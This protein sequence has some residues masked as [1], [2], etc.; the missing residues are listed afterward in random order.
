MRDEIPAA[1][2]ELFAAGIDRL[3]VPRRGFYLFQATATYSFAP[4]N[5]KF[6]TLML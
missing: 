2:T 3:T 1:K 4:L 6:L 5:L